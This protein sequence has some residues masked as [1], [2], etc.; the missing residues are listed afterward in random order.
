[1]IVA[2]CKDQAWLIILREATVPLRKKNKLHLTDWWRARSDGS[3]YGKAI[4][5]VNLNGVGFR[6][7]A[8][9]LLLERPKQRL[10]TTSPIRPEYPLRSF[11]YR[12]QR[13]D[14]H[15]MDSDY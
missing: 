8:I 13:G 11:L 1:M 6:F 3:G 5:G 7:F 12:I 2:S 14:W 15:S 4:S 9:G 10:S